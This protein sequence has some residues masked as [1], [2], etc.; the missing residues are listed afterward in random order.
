MYINSGTGLSGP[1]PNELWNRKRWKKLKKRGEGGRR[2][3]GPGICISPVFSKI[4]R[5]KDNNESRKR[6]HSHIP[7]LPSLSAQH[8][9]ESVCVIFLR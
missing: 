4:V 9:G 7:E 8:K 5:N 6:G 2:E 3:G 1:I